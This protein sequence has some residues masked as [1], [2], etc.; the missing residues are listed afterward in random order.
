MK[1]T[2]T[3][4]EL[5]LHEITKLEQAGKELLEKER[6]F[7][8]KKINRILAVLSTQVQHTLIV[9]QIASKDAKADEAKLVANLIHLREMIKNNQIS[10]FELEIKL[11]NNEKKDLEKQISHGR[12]P[13]RSLE[14]VKKII[15]L[16]NQAILILTTE[17]RILNE[18]KEIINSDKKDKIEKIKELW[19]EFVKT[20]YRE[21]D[22]LRELKKHY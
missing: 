3:P 11:R 15:D 6:I 22:I 13:S 7:D 5:E 17:I 9:I 10:D 20:C 14:S 19:R 1:S 12:K 8:E 18:L 2:I 4:N 21:A 16:S